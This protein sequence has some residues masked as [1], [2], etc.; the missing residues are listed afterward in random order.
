MSTALSTLTNE[1]VSF[2]TYDTSGQSN[3]AEIPDP[4]YAGVRKVV[5][6]DNQTT[7]LEANF[8]TDSTGSVLFGSTFNTITAASTANNPISFGLIAVSTDQWAVEFL[9]S[10]GDWTLAA[11]TGS[12]GQ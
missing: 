7:S 6:L 12:T 10:T 8:N 1:G 5:I 4:S 3:D 2:V 11:S 9:S